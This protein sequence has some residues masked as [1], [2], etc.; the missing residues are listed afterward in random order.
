MIQF[1][2]SKVERWLKSIVAL[3][4]ILGVVWGVFEFVS[5]T[6]QTIT[7]Q[8][9]TRD[10]FVE[11]RQ[12]IGGKIDTLK[13]SVDEIKTIQYNQQILLDNFIRSYKDYLSDYAKLNTQQYRSLTDDMEKMRDDLKKNQYQIPYNTEK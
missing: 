12:D 4:T 7:M 5:S 13:N 10:E 1:E 8:K 11:F 3:I 9:Q 2:F 6:R